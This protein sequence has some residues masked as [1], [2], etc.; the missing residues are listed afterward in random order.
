MHHESTA[1]LSHCTTCHQH[2][3]QCNF[4]SANKMHVFV[5]FRGI[6]A[7]RASCCLAARIL[8]IHGTSQGSVIVNYVAKFTYSVPAGDSVGNGSG[9][10]YTIST[11]VS[12]TISMPF[13]KQHSSMVYHRTSGILTV[14]ITA[15]VTT[16]DA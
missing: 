10:E 2:R 11:T 6:I 12:T 8:L 14:T 9:A 15:M 1:G 7:D 5:T 3:N 13:L 16:A 4:L